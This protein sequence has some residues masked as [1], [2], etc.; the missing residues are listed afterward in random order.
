MPTLTS[1]VGMVL[2]LI[3]PGTF[4][5]GSPLTEEGR[6]E[7][8]SRLRQV[9]LPRGYYLGIYPVTQGQYQ[10]VM[11]HNPSHFAT[12]SRRGLFLFSLTGAAGRVA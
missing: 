5:M 4:L 2:A 8:D 7:C 12:R 10:K 9:T 11:G 1:A 6:F 3:P